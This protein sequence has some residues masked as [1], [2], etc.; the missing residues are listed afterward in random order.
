VKNFPALF[1]ATGL[2][3]IVKAEGGQSYVADKRNKD[4]TPKP[5]R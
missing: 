1:A 5:G 2:F 3:E 4:R